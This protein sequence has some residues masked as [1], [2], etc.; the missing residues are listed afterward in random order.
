MRILKQAGKPGN[1]GF[2]EAARNCSEIVIWGRVLRI[3][4]L[5]L[6]VLRKRRL[7]ALLLLGINYLDWVKVFF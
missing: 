3:P 4:I 6:V 5:R 1:G 2:V 7:E